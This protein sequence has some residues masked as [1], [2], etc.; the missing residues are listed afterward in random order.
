MVLLY[1]FFII[2]NT[3][4]TSILFKYF[5]RLPFCWTSLNNSII[6]LHVLRKFQNML[7][8]NLEDNKN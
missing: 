8:Q 5:T 1:S 7:F 3:V 2:E 4:T 6:S